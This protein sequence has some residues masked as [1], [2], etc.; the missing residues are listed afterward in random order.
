[1]SVW[2]EFSS[3]RSVGLYISENDS[4]LCKA[5]MAGVSLILPILS[6]LPNCPQNFPR[7]T[8][9]GP[10]GRSQLFVPYWSTLLSLVNW[11]GTLLQG[12]P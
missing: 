1:M 8:F 11:V 4:V 9:L 3:S 2:K 10:S 12:S 7:I 6:I 5:G